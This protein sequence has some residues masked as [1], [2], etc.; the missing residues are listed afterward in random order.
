MLGW[1]LAT[2]KHPSLTRLDGR[3]GSGSASSRRLG[4]M[5]FLS[6]LPIQLHFSLGPHPDGLIGKSLSLLPPELV[7]PLG[8]TKVLGS[9]VEALRSA[10][11][12]SASLLIL[13]LT[14]RFY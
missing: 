6:F 1:L 2:W 12:P 7:P 13:S 14:S 10:E 8:C 4:N 5:T 11:I 9:S 3:H